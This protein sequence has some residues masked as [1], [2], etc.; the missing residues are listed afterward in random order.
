M[1]KDVRGELMQALLAVAKD[2]SGKIA[3]TIRYN[4]E[5]ALKEVVHNVKVDFQYRNEKGVFPGMIEVETLVNQQGR[6]RK[7]KNPSCEIE[8]EV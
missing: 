1:S 4:A 8:D 5:E 6:I 3:A 2:D 7:C